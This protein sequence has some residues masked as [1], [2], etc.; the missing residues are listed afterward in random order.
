MPISMAGDFSSLRRGVT[1]K[2]RRVPLPDDSDSYYR[3][4]ELVLSNM[5]GM[6]KRKS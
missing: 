2:D 5:I 4:R 1:I 6:G 3:D